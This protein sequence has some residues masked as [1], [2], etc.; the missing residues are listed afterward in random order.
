MTSSVRR[1]QAVSGEILSHAEAQR[2]LASGAPLAE[3]PFARGRT[4]IYPD[5]RADWITAHPGAPEPTREQVTAWY[6]G[7]GSSPGVAAIAAT[8]PPSVIA[9]HDVVI[10]ALWPGRDLVAAPLSASE[11]Y[12]ANAVLQM[13]GRSPNALPLDL[14]REALST[15][16]E[17]IDATTAPLLDAE[18]R[19]WLLDSAHRLEQRAELVAEV[20]QPGMLGAAQRHPV[21]TFAAGGGFGYLI[22]RLLSGGKTS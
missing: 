19:R 10:A 17:Y 14:A 12:V 8:L 22:A 7:G 15:R 9:A 6:L 11:S 13:R 3:D 18:A 2:Y 21:L 4:D 16:P 5:V 20:Y 1:P